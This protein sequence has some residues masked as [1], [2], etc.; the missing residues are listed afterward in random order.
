M[1]CCL[2]KVCVSEKKSRL[3]GRCKRLCLSPAKRKPLVWEREREREK[4]VYRLTITCRCLLCFSLGLG[5]QSSTL[6]LRILSTQADTIGFTYKEL[7]LVS[8]KNL[9][10]YYR[11]DTDI[12]PLP[13]FFGDYR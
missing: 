5:L 13:Y 9:K 2:M 4:S 12:F 10:K 7:L 1:L 3:T 8:G 6:I 11:V